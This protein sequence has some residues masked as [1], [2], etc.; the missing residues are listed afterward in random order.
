[1][2][3]RISGS[4]I[5]RRADGA[6]I[7]AGG[8]GY[9]IVLPPCV[10]EKV[11]SIAGEPIALEVYSV[12]NLDGK[13][14]RFTFYGFTN[15]VEREFFEALLTVASIGP[16]SAARAFSQPM[17]AIASAIARGD[18]AYLKSLPGIG[19]Q[20]ARDIVAKLQGKVAKFLL[21]QDAPP[22]PEHV[23]PDF[24]DEALAVLLQ[25][26]YKRSEAQT[27]IRETLSASPGIGDAETLLSQIYRRRAAKKEA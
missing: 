9:E 6:L 13:S 20:K 1:M 7:E 19:Q 22:A 16:R 11:T 27:M 10:A 25:L 3:S 18:H 4:L 15:A 14:G 17:S 8:L 26:E 23:M 5:E 2:F 12:V 21:I 24:A